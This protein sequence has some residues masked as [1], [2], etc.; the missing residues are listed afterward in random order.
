MYGASYLACLHALLSP[1]MSRINSVGSKMRF[2]I[3]RRLMM[4]T[5]HTW[6]KTPTDSTRHGSIAAFVFVK[7]LNQTLQGGDE[8]G[9]KPLGSIVLMFWLLQY[10]TTVF[11][12]G[13]KW[14]FLLDSVQCQPFIN[15]VMIWKPQVA[16]SRPFVPDPG[17]LHLSEE[18]VTITPFCAPI[19]G[20]PGVVGFKQLSHLESRIYVV[21][22]S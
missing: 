16:S 8:S 18:N 22:I 11:Q 3:E 4:I 9:Y 1:E 20:G 21:G 7:Y 6:L 5:L 17:S 19:R 15:F 14:S 2:K 12:I 10:D 13:T